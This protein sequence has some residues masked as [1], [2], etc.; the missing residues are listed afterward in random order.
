MEGLI[1]RLKKA[2]LDDEELM[3]YFQVHALAKNIG[4]IQELRSGEQYDFL[5]D[6]QR[7]Q[8]RIL[9]R[10]GLRALGHKVSSK[11]DDA[12]SVASEGK[13]GRPGLTGSES[14]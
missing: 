14:E 12:G 8:E 5:R 11:R 9:A 7:I 1:L 10:P 13:K 3:F 6:L 4:V 2:G